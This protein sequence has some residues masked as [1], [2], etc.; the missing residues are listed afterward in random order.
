MAFFLGLILGGVCF[1]FV[2]TILYLLRA[3]FSAPKSPYELWKA[4]NM[5]DNVVRSRSGK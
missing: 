1:S 2:A 4:E 3:K 5:R